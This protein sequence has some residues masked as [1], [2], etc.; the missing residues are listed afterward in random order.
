MSD[1]FLTDNGEYLDLFNLGTKL[2]LFFYPKDNTPGCT[3][4]NND[5]S[6]LYNEFKLLGFEVIGVSKDS[7]ES[8]CKFKNKYNLTFKLISDTDGIL[9]QRF[10]VINKKSL[11]GKFFLGIERSTFLL[12]EKFE[13][14]KE[15]RKVSSKNHANFILDFIKNN[16]LSK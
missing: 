2:V 10:G 11:Y 14:I 5:F 6:L 9:C 16:N 4:E 13:I 15:W 12:N 1:L 8:H 7:V 3:I